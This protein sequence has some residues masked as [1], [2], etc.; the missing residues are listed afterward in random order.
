M[1]TLYHVYMRGIEWVDEYAGSSN[2]SVVGCWLVGWGISV[3]GF[4][5][6]R[7]FMLSLSCFHDLK[8]RKTYF[9]IAHI[10]V[11][12]MSSLHRRFKVVGLFSTLK[13]TSLYYQISYQ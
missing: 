1:R 6:E 3:P 11:L 7:V 2:W 4:M 9:T 12:A 10:L 5:T 8:K 13:A